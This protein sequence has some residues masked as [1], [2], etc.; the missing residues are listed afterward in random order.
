M[1]ADTD[2]IARFTLGDNWTELFGITGCI[3]QKP[4]WFYEWAPFREVHINAITTI[5][6]E[7][8]VLTD[9][10]TRSKDLKV[11]SNATYA[12][13]CAEELHN[14]LRSYLHGP[15][16]EFDLSVCYIGDHLRNDTSAAKKHLG[17]KTIG[18]VEELADLEFHRLEELHDVARAHHET[19]RA[20]LGCTNSNHQHLFNSALPWF[21]YFHCPH[22]KHGNQLSFWTREMASCDLFVPTLGRL[23]AF[24]PHI[25]FQ[26]QHFA[27]VNPFSLVDTE[28]TKRMADIPSMGEIPPINASNE[29]TVCFRTALVTPNGS[30]S[31]SQGGDVP[32]ASNRATTTQ[33]AAKFEAWEKAQAKKKLIG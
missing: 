32:T 5:P 27:S 20:F 9:A 22:V 6:G 10:P 1:R 14:A 7:V 2:F 15:D 4:R 23:A 21:G 16:H 28:H 33:L 18:I 8:S 26:S 31:R 12:F 17:W 11:D 3:A 19:D 24:G 29:S 30:T 13:G 25:H